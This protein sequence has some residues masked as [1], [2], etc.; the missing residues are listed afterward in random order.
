MNDL[1]AYYITNL[2]YN[3]MFKQ[4]LQQ[5]IHDWKRLF[6]IFNV[7]DRIY[8]EFSFMNRPCVDL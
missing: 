3:T 2:P 7:K 4:M 1:I 5:W 8:I 6:N